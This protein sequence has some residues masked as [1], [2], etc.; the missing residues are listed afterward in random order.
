[1]KILLIHNFYQNAHIGGEDVVFRNE[2]SALVEALGADNVFKYTVSNDDAKMIQIVSDIWGAH[3]H[4]R[5][6]AALVQ[7][8][9]ISIV[10]VHNTFVGLTPTIF[11]YAKQAGAMVVHTLHNFRRWCVAGSFYRSNN[12]MECLEKGRHS[13]ISYKCYRGS[14]LATTLSTL[15]HS[16]YEQKNDYAPVDQYWYLSETQKKTLLRCGLPEE[17]LQYKPHWV[18]VDATL[19]SAEMKAGLLYVG[20]LEAEKGIE[21]LLDSLTDEMPKLTIIGHS[22]QLDAYK[23]AASSKNVQFLGRADRETTINEMRRAKYLIH[24]SVVEETFGL[25]M[26]EAMGVGT[27]VIG[28]KIGTREEYIKDGVNG[29]LSPT[30]KLS[31]TLRLALSSENY[32]KM[33]SE[34]WKTAQSFTKE[35]VLEKQIKLYERL[36]LNKNS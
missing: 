12:C 20:R 1:M 31:E 19:P 21:L 5:A 34:A 27:P 17:K 25:T 26:F 8:K 36:C 14:R 15:A 28:F 3:H 35:Y 16:W 6:I 4:G 30:G 13:A 18:H 23:K 22:E 33:S 32:S 10:H 7:E 29:Y 9:G 2:Y 24:S 11:K